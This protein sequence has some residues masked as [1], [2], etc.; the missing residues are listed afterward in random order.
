MSNMSTIATKRKANTQLATAFELYAIA[1]VILVIVTV[2][3]IGTNNRITVLEKHPAP[4]TQKAKGE[5]MTTEPNHTEVTV[6]VELLPCPFV[7]SHRRPEVPSPPIYIRWVSKANGF[8][9]VCP[10]CGTTSPSFIDKEKAIECW[11]ARTPSRP[12]AVRPHGNH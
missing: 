2:A 4:S 8:E 12:P 10:R 3:I 1:A 5:P 9:V 6:E 11:N 7:L